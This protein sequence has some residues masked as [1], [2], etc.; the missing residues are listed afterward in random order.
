MINKTFG[1]NI[2]SLQVRM[3]HEVKQQADMDKSANPGEQRRHPII[4]QQ[5]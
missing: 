1:S 4:T 5:L 2:I 3:V